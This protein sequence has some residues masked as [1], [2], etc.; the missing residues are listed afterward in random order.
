MKN[1]AHGLAVMAAW[2]AAASPAWANDGFPRT[3]LHEAEPAWGA[4]VY[5]VLFL[6]LVSAVA[7]KPSKRSHLD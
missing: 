7:F 2:L 3:V 4:I 6:I 5:T 1:L